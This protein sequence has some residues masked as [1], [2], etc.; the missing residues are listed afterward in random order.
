[1][2]WYSTVWI[3]YDMVCLSQVKESLVT[4]T[5]S[6]QEEGD[7]LCVQTAVDASR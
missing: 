4:V 3:C 1:M 7:R 2:I 6:L 5:E